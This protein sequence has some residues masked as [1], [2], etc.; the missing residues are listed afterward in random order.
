MA[1]LTATIL[2]LTLT[3]GHFVNGQFIGGGEQQ[4]QQQQSSGSSA[5]GASDQQQQQQQQQQS[6]EVCLNWLSKNKK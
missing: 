3:I 6:S 2:L 1:K 4:Q 5:F